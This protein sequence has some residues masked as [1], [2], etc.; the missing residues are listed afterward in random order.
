MKELGA[1]FDWG[2]E[3]R[4]V[5]G[6]DPPA[7]PVARLQY[8]DI[9]PSRSEALRRGESGD[10]SADDDDVVPLQAYT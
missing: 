9:A 2:R 6:P 1:E 4:D 8:G 5:D 10:A 3:F 7:N